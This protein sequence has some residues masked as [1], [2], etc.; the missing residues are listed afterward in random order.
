MARVSHYLGSR[1][2]PFCLDAPGVAELESLTGFGLWHLE[3][4]FAAM[5][6][7][8]REVQA[9]FRLGLTGAGLDEAE[10]LRLMAEHCVLGRMEKARGLGLLIL[11]DSIRG[12]TEAEG[13]AERP[14]KPPGDIAPPSEPSITAGSTGPQSTADSPAPA[15]RRRPSR[16]PK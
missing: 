10:A 8:T 3:A 7:T 16:A 9:V 12:I 6:C 4:R 13:E 15:S 2:Y 11:S 5:T 14:G 1:V